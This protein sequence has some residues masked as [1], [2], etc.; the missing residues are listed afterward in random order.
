[1]VVHFKADSD[2]RVSLYSIQTSSRIVCIWVFGS[3][4]ACVEMCF[5]R[6]RSKM[7]TVQIEKKKK[8]VKEFFLTHLMRLSPVA[9]CC[10]FDSLQIAHIRLLAWFREH[11]SIPFGC[12]LP[13]VV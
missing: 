7:E 9:K 11:H 5:E 10:C 12:C 6:K 2:G 13:C 1:M 8:Y 3:K 4:S